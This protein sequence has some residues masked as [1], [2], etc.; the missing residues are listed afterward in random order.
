M[1]RQTLTSFD[2]N[3]KQ[4]FESFVSLLPDNSGHILS[5]SLQIQ[6]VFT[7]LKLDI[8]DKNLKN[9]FELIEKKILFHAWMLE[10]ICNGEIS[11]EPNENLLS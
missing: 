10:Q 2:M 3:K 4:F 11:N 5:V 6:E 8:E 9:E 1:N 7:S